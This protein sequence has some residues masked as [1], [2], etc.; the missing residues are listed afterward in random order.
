[1]ET[2]FFHFESITC[3]RI[4]IWGRFKIPSGAFSLHQ[5][6]ARQSWSS[7]DTDKDPGSNPGPDATLIIGINL[8]LAKKLTHFDWLQRVKWNRAAKKNE[9]I[10]A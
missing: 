6:Q 3:L 1:M 4:F 7:Q 9:E 2:G 10:P 8:H 5:D